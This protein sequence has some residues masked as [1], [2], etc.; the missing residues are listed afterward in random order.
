MNIHS[1]LLKREANIATDLSLGGMEVPS[2]IE[3][4]VVIGLEFV[5]FCHDDDSMRTITS[6]L[7]TLAADT[8][9]LFHE[10]SFHLMLFGQIT[11]EVCWQYALKQNVLVKEFTPMI[12]SIKNCR[13]TPSIWSPRNLLVMR[14][15]AA[16]R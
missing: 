1:R 13:L 15:Q 12:F 10:M 9:D 16:P 3:G 8:D 2:I 4:L 14:C 5:P 6:L 11:L 7:C